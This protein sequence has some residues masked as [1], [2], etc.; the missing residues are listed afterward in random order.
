MECH[1]KKNRIRRDIAKVKK[2][3]ARNESFIAYY[4]KGIADGTA[5]PTAPQSKADNEEFVKRMKEE[6][7]RL[8]NELKLIA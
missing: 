3:I 7:V 1:Y 8:E 2:I 6:L 5:S 4:E